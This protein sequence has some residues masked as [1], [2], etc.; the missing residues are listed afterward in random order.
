MT[1]Y[2]NKPFTLIEKYQEKFGSNAFKFDEYKN[3]Y[4]DSPVLLCTHTYAGGND[5]HVFEED[6]EKSGWGEVSVHAFNTEEEYMRL[7]KI[8]EN[9]KNRV[10]IK[11]RTK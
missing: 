7:Y 10:Y 9:P 11:R 8:A 5:D 3:P 1:K 6:W 2:T 4:E